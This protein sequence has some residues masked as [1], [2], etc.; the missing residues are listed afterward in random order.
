M[1]AILLLVLLNK[2]YKILVLIGV[3]GDDEGL[4]PSGVS[5]L[6]LRVL[7]VK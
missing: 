1:F 6:F 2:E 3:V 4:G 7:F 5:F